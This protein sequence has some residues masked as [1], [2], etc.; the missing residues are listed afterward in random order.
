MRAALVLTASLLFTTAA[1]AADVEHAF[2]SAIPRGG[3]QR[4]VIDIPF[5]SFKVRNGTAARLAVSGVASR[6]YDSAKERAWAQ[7]VVNHTDV[8]LHVEGADVVVRRRFGRDAQSW[9]AKKFTDISLNLDLPPGIDV[10]F[11][12]AAGEIDMIGDFGDVHIDLRAGEVKLR[13]P[14][15]RVRELNAS[16]RIGEVRTN[17]GNEIVTRE[18]ILPGRTHFFNAAGKSHVDVHVTAGEVDVALTQ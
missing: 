9:R 12:T 1:L 6:D 3:V 4:V 11:E 5:G 17:L 10:R 8:E 14:R 13:V 2:Q 7:K 16:C 18:G 15:S